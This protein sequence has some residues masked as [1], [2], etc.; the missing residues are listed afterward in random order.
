MLEKQNDEIEIDLKEILIILISKLWIII[1]VTVIIAMLAFFVTKY[2]MSPLYESQ[3]KVYVLSKQD[4]T[5]ITYTDL[6]LGSQLT[7]DYQELIIS[8]PVLESVID[9]LGLNE[10]YES[11]KENISVEI[12]ADTRIISITVTDKDPY[13]AMNIANETRKSAA[14]QIKMVMDIQAVNIV[15]EANLPIVPSSPSILKNT[16]I[17]GII[18][19]FFI[20]SI[21]LVRYFLDDTIKNSED[22]ER[23]LSLSTLASIPINEK[24]KKNKNIKGKKMI[25]RGKM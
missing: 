16:I 10:N 20:I 15:E 19:M 13:V 5:N 3:T 24:N 7:K 17:S 14:E 6:Q 22:I 25:G 9:I 21:I 11:L 8:R 2:A 18:G 1:L 12:L 4:K 23:R